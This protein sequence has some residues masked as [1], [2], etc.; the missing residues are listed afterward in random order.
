MVRLKAKKLNG[1]ELE[2]PDLTIETETIIITGNNIFIF[3]GY[4][5]YGDKHR[6]II[7]WIYRSKNAQIA[8][9]EFKAELKKYL[10]K[11][12]SQV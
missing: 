4:E 8:K 1:F 7:T 3:K 12:L 9:R 5:Y 10:K 2:N 6:P 11:Y